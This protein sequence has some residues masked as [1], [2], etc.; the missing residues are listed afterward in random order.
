MQGSLGMDVLV[1]LGTSASYGYA[2]VATWTGGHE[3]HFFE[4]SAV[5]ICFVLLGKWMNALAVRRTSLALTKL[6]QLQ[7][8]T[9]IKVNSTNQT[10]ETWNPLSDPY[11]EEVVPI[12]SIQ[13]GDVVKV[14]KGASVP[15]DGVMFL[16]EQMGL[17]AWIGFAVIALGFAVTDGRLFSFLFRK[18]ST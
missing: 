5:L 1:A 14:L 6:M 11:R 16:G 10:K 13:P 8:K 17:E 9:A 3:Y 4:T 18:T 15:A 7:A 12:R 2:V